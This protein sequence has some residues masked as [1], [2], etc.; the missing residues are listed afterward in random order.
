MKGCPA[1]C[2]QGIGRILSGEVLI[3][4][5]GKWNF[6]WVLTTLGFAALS[7]VLAVQLYAQSGRAAVATVNGEKITRDQVYERLVARYGKDTVDQLIDNLLVEQEAR[8]ANVRVAPDE[9]QKEIQ[10]IKSRF[11]S[12][13]EFQATLSQYGMSM[14]DLQ[15]LVRHNLLLKKL[16]ADK[17]QAKVTDQ[18]IRE[19]FEK[20]R[21]EFDQPEQVKASHILVKTEAEAKAILDQL[22]AGADFAALA[23]EKSQD[24]GS[25][26][27]G[28]DLGYF[29]RGKMTKA[30]ED[31]A[32]SLPVGGL[33]GVVQTEYGYHIIKVTDRKPAQPAKFEDVKEKIREKLLNQEYQGLIPQYMEELRSKAQIQNTL[34]A[35]AGK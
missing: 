2:R 12:E 23:K 31:A 20:N 4:V 6:V 3:P 24:P 21:A 13:M 26:D 1:A 14:D 27:N 5:K 16:L 35:E 10:Q 32:F 33:S 19:Y 29:A 22:K 25:K 9:I 15:N 18:A 17:A 7:A 11:S 28:G 34:S 30:F 8:K